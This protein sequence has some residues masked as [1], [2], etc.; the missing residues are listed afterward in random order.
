M[1]PQG[2]AVQIDNTGLQNVCLQ[3]PRAAVHRGAN[4]QIGY[5]RQSLPPKLRR[6]SLHPNRVNAVFR[7]KLVRIN[8][9]NVGR[10]KSQSAPNPRAGLHGTG[11][12]IRARQ[13]L[14]GPIHGSRQQF[15]ADFGT[16]NAHRVHVV[17]GDFFHFKTVD[18]SE[19]LEVR[20]G[21]L[22][23]S[24]EVV[25]VA[26]DEAANVQV[27]HEAAS[28]KIQGRP[29]RKFRGKRLNHQ[30]IQTGLRQQFRSLFQSGQ[31]LQ[32]KLRMDDFSRMGVKSDHHGGT[33]QRGRHFLQPTK[34]G[35]VSRVHAVESSGGDRSWS[36]GRKG[37]HAQGSFHGAKIV[38]V[39]PWRHGKFTWFCR[40]LV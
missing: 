15:G 13:P 33:A 2:L 40:V 20:K 39:V 29:R 30:V 10:G 11:A 32:R 16:G 22:P 31:E 6:Q 5:R 38:L 28:D 3:L 36:D 35:A 1:H 34:D 7:Q 14:G 25:V 23:V 9:A 18:R 27:L 4:A 21:P 8:F 26:N 19:F 24:A 12:E 17:R 37:L